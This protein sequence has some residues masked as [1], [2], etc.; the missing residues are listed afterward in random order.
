[1]AAGRNTVSG[2]VLRI[3]VECHRMPAQPAKRGPR[4]VQGFDGRD[5]S[6]R[7]AVINRNGSQAEGGKA[8]GF[9]GGPLSTARHH[10]DKGWR[11][12]VSLKLRF[13]AET[14]RH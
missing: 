6:L 10:E 12:S 5:L 4:V 11:Q 3:D 8:L 13:E 14:H 9:L 1:M 2:H 7:E